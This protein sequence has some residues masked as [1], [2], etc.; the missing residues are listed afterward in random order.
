MQSV[1]ARSE[2]QLVI[3]PREREGFLH[4]LGFGIS[5]LFLSAQEKVERC[6]SDKKW[7]GKLY[8]AD[9]SGLLRDFDNCIRRWVVLLWARATRDFGMPA[10]CILRFLMATPTPYR[11]IIDIYNKTFLCL[12][13]IFLFSGSWSQGSPS[14]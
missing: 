9:E 6:K 3:G 11:L 8:G 13:P 10:V 12:K 5:S 14:K 7:K 2:E 1:Y 4:T